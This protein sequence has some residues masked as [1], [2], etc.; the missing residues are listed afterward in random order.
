MDN[1]ASDGAAGQESTA[2]LMD[3]LQ[4]A[5][6]WRDGLCP[7]EA[8][9]VAFEAMVRRLDAES[10]APGFWDG[11]H[12]WQRQRRL[13]QAR[14]ALARA[15]TFYPTL[16]P[17]LRERGAQLVRIA[18]AMAGL[19]TPTAAPAKVAKNAPSKRVRGPDMRRDEAR[20]R[21]EAAWRSSPGDKKSKTALANGMGIDRKTLRK[22]WE[23]YGLG[24]LIQELESGA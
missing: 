20:K 8:E 19:P 17:E 18:A 15:T 14:V 9:F 7:L 3:V 16:P 10:R 12:P 4:R 11:L 1:V 24:E 6:A 21:I 22:Y 2:S 5:S 13:E 23:P